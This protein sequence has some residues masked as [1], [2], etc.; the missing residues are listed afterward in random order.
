MDDYFKVDIWQQLNNYQKNW[1][2]PKPKQPCQF[3][4][5]QIDDILGTNKSWMT[6]S[7]NTDTKKF[8]YEK[9]K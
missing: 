8:V 4:L 3:K 5:V 6:E 7:W 9:A 2:K 1:L